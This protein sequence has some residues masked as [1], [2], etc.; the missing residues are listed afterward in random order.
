ML[1]ALADVRAA[2]PALRARG[3]KMIGALTTAPS[4]VARVA[5]VPILAAGEMSVLAQALQLV[6][7]SPAYLV[8]ASPLTC[9]EARA[10]LDAAVTAGMRVAVVRDGAAPRPLNLSDLIGAPMRAVELESVQKLVAGKRILVTGG[11]GSIGGELSRRI[12]GLAPAELTVMDNS[13][14]N[15]F[16]LGHDLAAIPHDAAVHLRFCDIRDGEAVRRIIERAKP[17]LVFHAAAMK[18][19]PMVEANACEGVLTNILGARNVTTAAADAGAHV[20][21]VSTDK[22]VNPVSVMGATKRLMEVY[23]QALDRDSPPNGLRFLTVRLGNVLGSAGSV[24]PVFERQLAAG[25][26]LTVTDPGA[27]RYFI[28]IAQA[29][30]FLLQAAAA[31]LE[32]DEVRGAAHILDMGEPL[33]VA[34]LARDMIRLSGRRPGRDVGIDFI[35]LRPGEKLHEELVAD[36]EVEAPTIGQGVKPV[37]SPPVSLVDITQRIEKLVSAARAGND[38]VA[39][40][41]LH[42]CVGQ[43]RARAATG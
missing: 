43:A 41:M 39:K 37:R 30:G 22:A 9:A 14:F 6:G 5:G 42:A 23:C 34:E 26:P 11:A 20:V 8:L 33:T 36:D 35:G 7:G 18:H 16:S 4:S 29:A 17:D 21:F 27:T 28:T 1:G 38:E 15:L 3:V 2:A 19:V 25:G 10:A 40:S 13:E 24:A 32:H 12:A 31:G